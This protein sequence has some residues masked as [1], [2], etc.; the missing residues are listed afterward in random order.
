M[1]GRNILNGIIVTQEIIHKAEKTSTSCF[2]KLDFGK[3]YDIVN[4]KYIM[5]ILQSRGFGPNWTRRIDQ[6]QQSAKLNV[7]IVGW[8]TRRNL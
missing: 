7:I 5:K 8:L 6:W 2:L 3:T 1:V 4:W